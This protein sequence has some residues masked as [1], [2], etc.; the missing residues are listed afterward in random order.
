VARRY[1]EERFRDAVADP[2]VRTLAD[3]CR[4]L[5]IV[6]RG[7]NYESVRGYAAELGIDLDASLVQHDARRAVDRSTVSDPTV[8]RLVASH[9][10]VSAMIDE[11]GW[12]R[13]GASY[14]WMRAAIGRLQLDTSHLR[15]RGWAAGRERPDRRRPLEPYL[16]RGRLV[17]SSWLRQRLVQDDYLEPTCMRCRR[18]TWEGQPI[19]L[20]LDHIDGDR[21]NNLLTNLRLLCPN[22]HA[23]TPTYRGRNIGRWRSSPDVGSEP[24][25][26]GSSP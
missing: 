16:T 17:P 13:S 9:T 3:L 11:L 2:H 25:D 18:G 22:C 1:T 14:R 5:G 15:G 21:T 4:A 20:E 26:A 8:R 10:T 6:P 19:P 7:G 12:P 24:E 23:L